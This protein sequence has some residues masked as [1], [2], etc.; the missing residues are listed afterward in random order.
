MQ[1]EEELLDYFE[2]AVSACEGHAHEQELVEL[3][4]SQL[5]DLH[6]GLQKS[7]EMEST[8]EENERCPMET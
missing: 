6:D 4:V 3:L 2:T 7:R 1:T 8:N 5:T